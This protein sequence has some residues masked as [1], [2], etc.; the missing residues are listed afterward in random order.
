MGLI[1]LDIMY[2]LF[3]RNSYCSLF[4]SLIASVYVAVALGEVDSFIKML[5][6]KA[7]L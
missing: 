5:K 3:H 7:F 4:A 1:A 2:V 6:V